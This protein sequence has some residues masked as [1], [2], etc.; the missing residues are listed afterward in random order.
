[1]SRFIRKAL[2]G[3]TLLCSFGLLD[4]EAIRLESGGSTNVVFTNFTGNAT[5]DVNRDI[6]EYKFEASAGAGGSVSGVTNQWFQ[7]G[8]TNELTAQPTNTYYKFDNWTWNANQSTSTNP[9]NGF[10]VTNVLRDVRANFSPILTS[11]G[12]PHYWL[13]SYGFDPTNG[14]SQVVNNY[15]LAQHYQLDTN[16]NSPTGYFHTAIQP[17]EVLLKNSSSKVEY[18]VDY[19]PFLIQGGWTEYTNHIP[20]QSGEIRV[21][22]DKQGFYRGKGKRVE[23]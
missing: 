18:W 22:T 17:G 6:T 4:A 12:T 8:H 15:T 5:A 20:G 23:E 11:S 3:L 14:D 13:A 1:M 21:P 7:S 10:I 9:T 19:R 16:P 2:S